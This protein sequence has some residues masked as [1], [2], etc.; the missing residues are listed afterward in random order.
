MFHKDF[1]VLQSFVR[2]RRSTISLTAYYQLLAQSAY[3]RKCYICD[4]SCGA[5]QLLVGS[6]L[7]LCVCVRS[8]CRAHYRIAQGLA[9]CEM[10]TI[11]HMENCT[12]FYGVVFWD[13]PGASMFGAKCTCRLCAGW[14]EQGWMLP[15]GSSEV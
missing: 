11:E 7:M 1:S 6:V 4:N 2:P 13:P 8:F 15:G 5:S 9:Q 3:S 12:C 10:K 14:T